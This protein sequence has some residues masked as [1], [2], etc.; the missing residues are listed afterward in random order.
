ML[1]TSPVLAEEQP[2]KHMKN[3]SNT[4]SQKVKDSSPETKLKVMEYC[5]ITDREFKIAHEETQQA[6]RKFRKAV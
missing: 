5:G 2:S 1:P 6:A 4:A 3:Y